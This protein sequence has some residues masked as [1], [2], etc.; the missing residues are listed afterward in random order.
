MRDPCLSAGSC[1][2]ARLGLTETHRGSGR[3]LNFRARS[4]L[5]TFRPSP[6][7]D[8]PSPSPRLQ[9]ASGVENLADK[10]RIQHRGQ[11][12]RGAVARRMGPRE[13]TRHVGSFGPYLGQMLSE[14]GWGQIQ[15]AASW[16]RGAESKSS[17][18]LWRQMSRGLSG[19]QCGDLCDSPHIVPMMTLLPP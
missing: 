5:Q 13:A 3:D 16:A 10:E 19:W 17:A 2:E 15:R 18:V 7:W 4:S 14:K 9:H 11:L 8:P 1:V 12:P 6:S